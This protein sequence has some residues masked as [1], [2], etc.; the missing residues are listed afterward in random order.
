MVLKKS[1][2][3]PKGAVGYFYRRGIW[4]ADQ[5]IGKLVYGNASG[6]GNNLIGRQKLKKTQ[7]ISEFKQNGFQALGLPYEPS[8]IDK[9]IS[10]YNQLI[11]DDSKTFVRSNEGKVYMRSLSEPYKVIPELGE[12]INEKV[13]NTIEGYYGR[14]FTVKRVS[15]W[16]NY[17]VSS[18]FMS[19]S[20]KE[21]LSSR[22]HCDRLSI[23]KTKLF[24]N[25]TDVTEKDGPFH[26]Q[27]IQRTKELIKKGFGSREDYKLSE[28]IVE[29]QE[30]VVKATG[31][32]GS[33]VLANTETCYHKAGIPEPG[34]Y[35][36]IIQF[37]FVPSDEPLPSDW[38]KHI[39]P[40]FYDEHA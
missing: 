12:L 23:E 7:S 16:R 15:C 38:I 27:S 40:E 26:I 4:K 32:S 13:K 3:D 5:Y 17:H 11:M 30:Y 2:K 36:D 29:D 1:A 31:P 14:H 20:K 9:I 18:D 21:L 24:V 37:V 28:K 10:K 25:L 6:L 33:A 35:R 8:L 39:Q 19:G 34:R 22:W